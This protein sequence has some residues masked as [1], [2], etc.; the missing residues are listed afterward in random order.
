MKRIILILSFLIVAAVALSTGCTGDL[1]TSDNPFYEKVQ[2]SSGVISGSGFEYSNLRGYDLFTAIPQKY[3]SQ[4]ELS[5]NDFVYMEQKGDLIV[6][7][8]ANGGYE[9]FI[10]DK[11]FSDVS[12]EYKDA[13]ELGFMSG[14]GKGAYK[15]YDPFTG[16]S[17]SQPLESYPAFD[18]NGNVVQKYS[19]NW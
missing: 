13:Q 11:F 15:L 9:T 6:F 4:Q 12:S 16:Q 10:T 17:R 2:E 3:F 5:K 8:Y 19:E 18:E 1:D 14:G 7:V